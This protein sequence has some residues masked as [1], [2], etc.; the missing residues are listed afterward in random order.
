MLSNVAPGSRLS[1][2]QL[3]DKIN[4]LST[5]ISIRG[6]LLTY[7]GYNQQRVPSHRLHIRTRHHP[8]KKSSRPRN[9]KL[10]QQKSA[11]NFHHRTQRACIVSRPTDGCRVAVVRE[12]KWKEETRRRSGAVST[13]QLCYISTNVSA[14]DTDSFHSLHQYF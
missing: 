2:I 6:L 8:R 1:V 12:L 14:S 7:L 5:I 4:S 3:G 10:A 11:T 9:L 13:Q